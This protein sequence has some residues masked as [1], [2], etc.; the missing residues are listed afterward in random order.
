MKRNR[1]LNLFGRFKVKT[2]LG[3]KLLLLA[4]ISFLI[5]AC[6]PPVQE[7]ES[8]ESK[9]GAAPVKVTEVKR[10][11]ISEKL[12]YTGLIEA[13]EQIVISPEVGGRIA[14]IN[15]EEGER[16]QKGQI[17]AEMD[18]RAARL[19]L[20]QAEAGLAVAQANHNDAKRNMQ[21]MERLRKENAVSEQQYEKIEL[22]FD[23]AEAQLKQAQASLDLAEH[24]LEV[25]IMEAPFSGVVASKNAEVGDIINPMMGGGY[26]TASGVLTLA[27]FSIVKIHIN[28]SYEDVVRIK[29]GQKASL[30]L[31][32]FPE[33]VFSGQVTVVN[34]AADPVS[35]KFN[36]EVQVSNKDLFLRPNVFGDVM[37][38]VSTHENALVIPQEA[39][40]EGS[41]VFTADQGRAVKKEITI[42]LENTTLLEV[43]TG[44]DEGEQVIVKGNYGLQDGALIEISEVIK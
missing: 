25:S 30:T 12:Y 39:V 35:K 21:R 17:I 20:Q 14:K 6:N 27:D 13:R 8:R 2:N 37:L 42:G 4:F 23:A 44:L 32:T 43:L 34:M 18:T 11:K 16:V 40:V 5:F 15:V 7:E 22:A 36:V 29:K 33:R 41:Y 24:N 9:E 10:Q 31:K 19:Q 28:V 1:R 38:E 26:S 3:F